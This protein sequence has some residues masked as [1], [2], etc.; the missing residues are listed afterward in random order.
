MFLARRRRAQTD[1]YTPTSCLHD[2]CTPPSPQAGTHRV[3]L[4]RPATG[5][6]VRCLPARRRGL[7]V[8]PGLTGR[9]GL[10]HPPSHTH[11]PGQ[12][13][14]RPSRPQSRQSGAP[15]ARQPRRPPC[16]QETRCWV[17]LRGGGRSVKRDCCERARA[18]LPV[19]PMPPSDEVVSGVA[20]VTTT[21]KADGRTRREAGRGGAGQ[22][23]T[24]PGSSPRPAALVAVHILSMAPST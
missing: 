13:A 18:G 15:D 24:M 9:C 19:Q 6:R 21:T 11:T 22:G 12:S 5:R 14:R 16:R 2:T 23:I 1:T 10:P 8:R 4:G 3:E 17:R 7:R 20:Q